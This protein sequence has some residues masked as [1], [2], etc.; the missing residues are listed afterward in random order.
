VV[1]VT[2]AL[3][4]VASAGGRTAGEADSRFCRVLADAQLGSL[5]EDMTSGSAGAM[6]IAFWIVT[7]VAESA[8]PTGRSG[9]GSPGELADTAATVI[10]DMKAALRDAEEMLKAAGV[11]KKQRQALAK[12]DLSAVSDIDD[13][14]DAT[15][16]HAR[17]LKRAARAFRPQARSLGLPGS[18][19]TS[20]PFV[21]AIA[22]CG[23]R[24]EPTESSSTTTTPSTLVGAPD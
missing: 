4:G 6:A 10:N 21:E 9:T 19:A 14:A 22:S 11:S 12:V 7:E 15:G 8:P 23:V 17:K 13:I 24:L 1:A 2:L 18:G 3:G 20:G 5:V 16:I